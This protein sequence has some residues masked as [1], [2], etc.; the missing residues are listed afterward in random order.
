MKDRYHKKANVLGIDVSMMRVDKAVNVSMELMRGKG[1]PVIYFLSAVSSLLC[2][3]NA[4]AAEYVASCN[5]VLSGDRHMELAVRHQQEDGEVPQGI[6]EFA[7]NYLKRLFVK[8]NREGRSIY[9]IMDQ[10]EHLT[11]LEEYMEESYRSI[12]VHGGIIG[13]NVKGE[14]D[15]IVNEIN[16]CI[17]DIV[18]VCLPA[19]RQIKF[20][21]K[22]AAMMNTR[23]CI[24]IVSVQPLIRK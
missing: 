11:S 17:P 24:L 21:E 3:N 1:L 13:K 4:G 22:Y 18:F 12:E 7:D 6:G 23:L 8:L 15:R 9:T 2:Q 10:E 5:L 14:A 19:E 20:M 16:A